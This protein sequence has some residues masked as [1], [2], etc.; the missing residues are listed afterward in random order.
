MFNNCAIFVSYLRFS[1]KTTV[2]EKEM[3]IY[4]SIDVL[5]LRNS[6]FLPE[7]G[8]KYGYTCPVGMHFSLAG[9][10]YYVYKL[11]CILEPEVRSATHSVEYHQPFDSS[12]ITEVR[13]YVIDI[14]CTIILICS[15]SLVDE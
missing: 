10:C 6:T 15:R 13:S 3:I 8:N 2:S 9:Y 4:K 11:N 14:L 5:Y 7:S 1:H 12:S